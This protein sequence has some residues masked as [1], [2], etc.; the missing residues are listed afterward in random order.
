MNN[1]S[2]SQRG[3]SSRIGSIQPITLSL[4]VFFSLITLSALSC[5]LGTFY[6]D[7]IFNI[8]W[9]ALPFP[10]LIDFIKYINSTDIHPPVS[11]VLNKLTFDVLGSWKAVQFINGAVNAAA[12]AFFFS[13]TVGKVATQERLLLTLALATAVTSE[14]W[15]T[16]LRWN[17]YFNP[18]FLV[19]YTIALSNWLSFVGRIAILAVGTVFL[20]YT[21]YLTVVAAPVLWGTCLIVSFKELRPSDI[22]R[23]TIILLAV[24]IVCL[25]QFYILLSVHLPYYSTSHSFSVAYSIVQSA[26]ALTVGNAIFPID[27]IPGLFL[28][29]LGVAG[30]SSIRKILRDDYAAVLFYGILAGFTLLS[31]VRLGVEGRNAVFL[32]PVALT[33]IVLAISRSALWIR[34]P[35]TTTLVLLQIISVYNFVLHRD[36][37][38]GSFN[39]PF[40]QAVREISA[41]NKG[42]AGKTYVFTYDPV[43]T[44]LV[45]QVGGTVSSPYIRSVYKCALGAGNGLRSGRRHLSRCS[46]TQVVRAI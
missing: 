23:A 24:A 31:V 35:A 18:V 44:Y 30:V 7:E 17:A 22:A 15:G 8:R 29:L 5:I 4:C 6:D 20:F 40:P 10:N 13:Q 39:T 27:Y 9:T 3:L 42:C 32:Y 16:S 36:T 45:T 41:L 34:V 25:P 11:Y 28:I 19:L 46:S 26:A 43:L 12:I 2:Q 38:K 37:A 33:L 14:M 21:S 1:P